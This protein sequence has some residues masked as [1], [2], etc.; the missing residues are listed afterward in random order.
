VSSEC[1]DDETVSQKNKFATKD[2]QISNLV[3]NTSIAIEPSLDRNVLEIAKISCA[4]SSLGQQQLNLASL[5]GEQLTKPSCTDGKKYIP[6][7]KISF[8]LYEI[9]EDIFDQ[10]IMLQVKLILGGFF[11][12]FMKSFLAN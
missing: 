11:G 5:T 1:N 6:S 2:H 10:K 8:D 4:L 7:T 12:F 3:S 9:S